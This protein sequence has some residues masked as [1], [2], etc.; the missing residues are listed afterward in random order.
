MNQ[1]KTCAWTFFVFTRFFSTEGAS[2][3]VESTW[4]V[5]GA[6]GWEATIPTGAKTVWEDCWSEWFLGVGNPGSEIII[7]YMYTWY[8]DNSC[9]VS[10]RMM[11]FKM[12]ISSKHLNCLSRCSPQA[13]PGDLHPSTKWRGCLETILGCRIFTPTHQWWQCLHANEFLWVQVTSIGEDSVS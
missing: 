2:P 3:K 4:P 7:N 13:T 1:T 10:L 12:N 5:A 9:M 6:T 8:M 11:M